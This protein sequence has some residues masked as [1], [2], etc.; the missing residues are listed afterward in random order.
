MINERIE[1]VESLQSDIAARAAAVDGETQSSLAEPRTEI[2]VQLEKAQTALTDGDL[3]TA[4]KASL[5][6]HDLAEEV[7]S[8]LNRYEPTEIPESPASTTESEVV[9]DRATS[10]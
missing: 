6:A 3:D 1:V 8:I 7:L 10:T 9:T 5:T 4:D 2:D